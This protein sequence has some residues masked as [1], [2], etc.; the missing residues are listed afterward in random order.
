MTTIAWDGKT[1]AADKGSWSDGMHLAVQKV[2]KVTA[3]DGR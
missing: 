3:P 1:L 2:H